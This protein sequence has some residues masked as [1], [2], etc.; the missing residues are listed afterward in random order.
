MPYIAQ[1]AVRRLPE[2]AIFGNDYPTQ[3]GTGVRDYLH[4]VDLAKGHVRALS[5][6]GK[7]GAHHYNLGTGQGVSVLQIVETF[8]RVTGKRVPY[9]FAPRR[10]G[11]LAEVYADVRKAE[12]ELDWRAE[13]GLEAML[14]D[15]WRWQE[16][17]PQGYRGNSR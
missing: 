9:R 2:L 12:R 14:Q 17:N 15:T 7:L 16:N 8:E 10:A 13:L 4:V 1:V 11:D 3:D 5:C 6:L